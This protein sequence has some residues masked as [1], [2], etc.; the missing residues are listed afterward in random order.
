MIAV[1]WFIAF[2]LKHVPATW[3]L[4]LLG[5][6]PILM[7]LRLAVVGESE[8]AD[9]V[10]SRLRPQTSLSLNVALITIATCGADHIGVYVPLFAQ[11]SGGRLA[12][13]LLTFGVMLTVFCGLGAQLGRR[14]LVVKLL[15][16]WGRW[17]MAAVYIGIGVVILVE[18]GALAHWFA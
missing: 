6:I 1:S 8:D 15:E 9:E 2:G 14:P 11:L 12:V 4:G 13:V 7:G 16:R 10:S 3:A 18:S 17:L 5:V